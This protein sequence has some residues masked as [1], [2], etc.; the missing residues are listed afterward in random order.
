MKDTVIKTFKL[1]V[2]AI[3]EGKWFEVVILILVLI[4]II[5]LFYWLIS[6]SQRWASGGKCSGCGD[7]GTITGRNGRIEVC[8]ICRGL[9]KPY[10]QEDLRV[11][12]KTKR[13]KKEVETDFS[14]RILCS[15]G[16]CTGVINGQG[17]CNICG[18]PHT[19]KSM[20]KGTA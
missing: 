11:S 20:K 13:S 15:D 18:K 19:T 14:Q 6:V 16:N 4:G 5:Y 8:P 12:T 9:G 3:Q 10:R 7:V 2:K 17:V 1:L